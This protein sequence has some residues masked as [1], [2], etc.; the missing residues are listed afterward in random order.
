MVKIKT[1]LWIIVALVGL[2]LVM[3]YNYDSY[4]KEKDICSNVG[5]YDNCNH[6]SIG[7]ANDCISFGQEYLKYDNGG[8]ASEECW[9][10]LNNETYQLW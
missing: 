4:Y 8:F 5:V 6:R 10:K 1:A 9:C 3:D 7:C 2:Y